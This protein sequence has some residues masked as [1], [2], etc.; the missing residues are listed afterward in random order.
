MNR[1][2]NAVQ[3]QRWNG[4]SGQH[5]I[6]H[7]ERHLAGH[8][9]LVTH[10]FDAAAISPGERVL[11]VGCGCGETTIAA[12][13]A[14]AGRDDRGAG[15]GASAG[16]GGGG[17]R[18]AG[19][20]ALG[21]DLSAPMLA[22]ARRLAAEAGLA[23]VGLVRADAQASP[24]RPG[25]CDVMISSFGVMFFDDPAAAFANIIA[26]LR[27]PGRLAFL[28]WQQNARNELFGILLRAFMAAGNLPAPAESP[29]TDPGR[30]C[31]LLT[32]AGCADV[33][34]DAVSESAWVGSDV[35]DVLSYLSGMRMV[36][37]MTA[38]LADD[39][40]TQRALAAIADQ[41]AARQRPDGVWFRAAAWLVTARRA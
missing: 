17:D 14:A 39:A 36:R 29:F 1:Q 32:G 15:A 23:N 4:E 20:G 7:R 6:T 35:A 3:A 31:E 34:I 22:V 18:G 2:V 19:G 21:L 8:Q 11:D 33:Q 24:L 10:L 38:E 30:V 37:L 26:A 12:A 41:C 9:R 13:G 27:R 5:W 28:C 25:S 40:L 16:A